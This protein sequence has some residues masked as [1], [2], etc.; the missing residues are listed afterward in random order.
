MAAA[1]FRAV[2]KARLCSHRLTGPTAL[3]RRTP[4]QCLMGKGPSG[5][6][7]RVSNYIKAIFACILMGLLV[8]LTS[9]IVFRNR[10]DLTGSELWDLCN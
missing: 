5:V 6:G 4:S 9:A 2:K 3:A 1:C 8:F 7:M 10:P